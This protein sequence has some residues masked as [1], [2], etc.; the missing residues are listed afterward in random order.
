[1]R[2]ILNRHGQTASNL[3][4]A[5]DTAAP[6]APLD[7]TG[8]AQAEA[9]VE[10]LGTEGDDV[11][12]V[13]SSTLLR[14]KMTAAP[15]ARS[16]GLDVAE[17]AGLTEISAGELEMRNDPD[18]Q[19]AYRDVFV[20]WLSGDL[21][22]KIPGGED[23]RSALE[24]FDAVIEG[25]RAE[26]AQPRRDAGDLACD[27]EHQLR[28]DIALTAAT[29]Q[30]RRGHTGDGGGFQLEASPL[31]GQAP[32]LAQRGREDPVGSRVPDVCIG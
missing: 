1:M 32:G 18:A 16:R 27:P 29:G 28:F 2:L 17:H 24:R 8:L 23:G 6:G 13:Y 15:L 12:A 5:L 25:A 14:A 31:A 20:R 9:L 26:G 22:A 4:Q 10:R 7:E 3:A 21:E 11:D 19:L 30:H